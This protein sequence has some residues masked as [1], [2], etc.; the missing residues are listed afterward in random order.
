MASPRFAR[1]KEARD[2]VAGHPVSFILIHIQQHVCPPPAPTSSQLGQDCWAA[3][4]GG[5]GPESTNDCPTCG[6]RAHQPGPGGVHS[7]RT[8]APQHPPTPAAAG[9]QAE[10]AY[11][12]PKASGLDRKASLRVPFRTAAQTVAGLGSLS[13]RQVAGGSYQLTYLDEDMLIG[14]ATALGGVFIFSRAP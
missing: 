13:S 1:D 7:P 11:F 10:H 3:F 12:H 6:G 5:M 9:H 8:A 2:K 4:G 14:R